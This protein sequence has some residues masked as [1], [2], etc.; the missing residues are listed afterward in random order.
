M[1]DTI[2][3][4]KDAAGPKGWSDDPAE[5]APHLKEWRGKYQGVS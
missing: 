5:I 4:L 3:R 2:A 1:T